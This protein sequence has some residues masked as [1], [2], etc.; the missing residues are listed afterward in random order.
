VLHDQVIR[1]Q[2]LAGAR[3]CSLLD[4][5]QRGSGTHPASYPIGSIGQGVK[6]PT[7]LPSSAEVKNL[8]SCTSTP[9]YIFMIWGLIKHRDNFATYFRLFQLLFF[10][11]V[12]LEDAVPGQKRCALIDS[13][14]ESCFV[15]NIKINES[16]RDMGVTFDHIFG[17]VWG[18]KV[19]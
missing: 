12:I 18:R 2:F 15:R 10:S 4:S 9:P 14:G 13:D 19:V 3:Y 8:S 1:V 16:S 17:K 11:Q 7:H 5:I 6:L